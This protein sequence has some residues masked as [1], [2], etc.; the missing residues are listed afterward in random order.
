MN[1]AP[2]IGVD[3]GGRYVGIV[4]LNRDDAIAEA[5]VLTRGGDDELPGLGYVKWVL[6]EVRMQLRAAGTVM[7]G[8]TEIRPTIAL[9]GLNPPTPHMGMTNVA[10]IIGVGIVFGA[11][12][13]Q[14][15]QAVI[16]PPGGN[17]K[18]PDL[19]YPQMIRKYAR[20]G[21]P[22]EHARSAYDVA[23]AGQRMARHKELQ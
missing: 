1:R 15:P 12:L 14:W 11:V 8:L 16:V 17:G 21:G 19:A 2:V 13:G 18:G 5:K 3:P 10:G 20:L 22:S 6:D 9:E 23:I 7:D 4:R